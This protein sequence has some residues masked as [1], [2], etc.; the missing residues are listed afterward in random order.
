MG[1]LWGTPKVFGGSHSWSFRDLGLQLPRAGSRL[2]PRG[3]PA[4]DR[5]AP[6]LAWS[7]RVRAGLCVE[8]RDTVAVRGQ[9]AYFTGEAGMRPGLAT[10]TPRW[11]G[12]RAGLWPRAPEHPD[13]LTARA[14]LADWTRRS[15]LPE[16]RRCDV[17]RRL[18][19]YGLPVL[20]MAGVALDRRWPMPRPRSSASRAG[21]QM[22]GVHPTWARPGHSA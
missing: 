13:T 16:A 4:V 20:L 9:V 2:S 6:I 1:F 3:W 5:R 21:V 15:A 14:N 17:V 18:V 12:P 11:C 19:G 10:S 8:N 7:P 22:H